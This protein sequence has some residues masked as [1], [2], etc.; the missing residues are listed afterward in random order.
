MFLGPFWRYSYEIERGSYD[1][2]DILMAFLKI[3]VWLLGRYSYSLLG[4]ILMRFERVSYDMCDILMA[5]LEVFLWDLNG[6]LMTRG[7]M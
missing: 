2:C 3:F 1:L 7:S 6:F 4:D 5:F